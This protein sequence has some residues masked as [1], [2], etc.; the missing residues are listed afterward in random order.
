V[1][2]PGNYRIQAFQAGPGKSPYED[3]LQS[4][5]KKTRVRIVERVRR[6]ERGQFGDYKK[7]DHSLYELRFFFGPGYRIYFGD[8]RGTLILLLTGG[9]KKSQTGDIRTAQ[10]YWKIFQEDNP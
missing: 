5:D 9:D 10:R 6:L 4:L 8:Y 7:I 1:L 2:K 3:W